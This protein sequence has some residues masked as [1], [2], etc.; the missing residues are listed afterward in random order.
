MKIENRGLSQ[1][2]PAIFFIKNNNVQ[3]SIEELYWSV[4]IIVFLVIF[5]YF[6]KV[7]GFQPPFVKN[8]VTHVQI[9]IV[10]VQLAGN[11]FRVTRAS[12]QPDCDSLIFQGSQL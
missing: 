7:N 2:A 9:L 5:G 1:S 11:M 12:F 4:R 3:S 10:N 8:I 6:I